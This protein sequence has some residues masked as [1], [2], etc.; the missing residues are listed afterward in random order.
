MSR[1]Y[2]Q[3]VDHGRHRRRRR[4]TC[5]A[6]A[7]SS[8]SRLAQPSSRSAPSSAEK[9]YSTRIRSA[10]S[11]GRDQRD[12]RHLG[13]RRSHRRVV[14]RR[15][16][17]A[18]RLDARGLAGRALRP[19]QRLRLD[20]ESE[21]RI[22]VEGVSGRRLARHLRD[23]VSRAFALRD[24][25]RP[26]AGLRDRARS[27][28]LP[29]ARPFESEL[30][31]LRAGE[32]ERQSGAAARAGAQRHRRHRL[33][34]VARRV[35]HRRRI[36]HRGTRPDPVP[37]SGV[38]ARA[39]GR[40]SGR[41]RSQPRRHHRPSESA[42]H[43][44]WRNPALGHRR[45]RAGE[46]DGRRPRAVSASTAATSGCR[47]TRSRRRQTLPW[48]TGPAITCSRS[49]VRASASAWTAGRGEA[50]SPSTTPAATCVRSRPRTRPARTRRQTIRSS[51]GSSRGTRSICSSATTAF[52]TS[53]S[54]S[55]S[56]TSAMCR[57][58]ST[59]AG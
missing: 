41:R 14:V 16:R 20:D 28:D 23:G 7:K 43:Q 57:R 54:A 10:D 1:L 51:A 5:A 2:P 9:R 48:K 37:R 24:V 58:R 29:G 26:A 25:A 33:R 36:S 45:E 35:V 32:L 44:P 59:S 17:A 30:R 12:L 11:G 4:S 56:T 39:R 34:A 52:P 22:E 38:P 8:A 13:F 47:T 55:S 19:L 18:A 3:L 6:H 21:G 42:V 53:S 46:G 27:A 49:R 31:A 40:L 50:L 15:A